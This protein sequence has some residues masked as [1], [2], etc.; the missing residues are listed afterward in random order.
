MKREPSLIIALIGTAL[1]LLAAFGLPFLTADQAALVIVVLNAGLA[2]WNAV[3]VRPVSPAPFVYLVGAIAT[4]VGAYGYDLSQDK[5]GAINAAV[6]ALLALS[7]RG[8]VTPQESPAVVAQ[9]TRSF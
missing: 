4:C 1:S 7:L 6:L 8:N 3:K 5:V 2:A 9:S